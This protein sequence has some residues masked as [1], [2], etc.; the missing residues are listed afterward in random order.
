MTELEKEFKEVIIN[1][2]FT[3]RDK[4]YVAD[5]V[6]KTEKIKSVIIISLPKEKC[7]EDCYSNETMTYFEPVVRDNDPDLIEYGVYGY[8]HHLSSLKGIIDDLKKG[9]NLKLECD[10]NE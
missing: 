10:I 8:E 5:I 3:K 9:E 4:E 1:T 7:A 6:R 2:D